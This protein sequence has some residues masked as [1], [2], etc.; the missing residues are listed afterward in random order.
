LYVLASLTL[1][2]SLGKNTSTITTLLAGRLPRNRKVSS[3]LVGFEVHGLITLV[4]LICL[5]FRTGCASLGRLI[6]ARMHKM[7]IIWKKE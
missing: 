4:E 5:V 1:S 6:E 7:R 3:Y 2:W